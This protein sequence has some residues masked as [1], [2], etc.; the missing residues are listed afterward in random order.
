MGKAIKNRA[1]KQE[2]VSQRQLKLPGF[3][4]PF[5]QHL[6]PTNRWVILAQNI[7][8]DR[9]VNFY[10]KSVKSNYGASR[11]NGRIAIGSL[12]IKFMND[13]S[14]REVLQAI[15]ENIYMQYFLGLSSFHPQPLFDHSLLTEIRKRLPMEDLNQINEII[16]KEWNKVQT[17]KDQ[18]K[19]NDQKP[20]IDPDQ[21]KAEEKKN[22]ADQVEITHEGTLLID[23]T[24]CPQNIAYPT[25]INLLSESREILEGIIDDLHIESSKEK[26][27]RTYRQIARKEYL[28]VAKSR[29]PSRKLIRVSI[30]KQL[31][32]VRRNLRILDEY[33][34][35]Q[36]LKV[37]GA[38]RLKQTMVI[39]NLYD[40]Q[41]EMY[42]TQSHSVPDRIVNIHQPYVRPIVRGKQKA[43]VE[44][45]AKIQLGLTNGLC[46][47]DYFSWDAYNEGQYLK[48]SV[49]EYK[50]R[51]GKYP[52]EI[53]ADQIYCTREN[54]KYLKEL[55]ITLKAKP[56]GRP[57]AMS[58][59]VSPGERN[60]IEGKFGQAKIAYGLNLIKA[61]LSS[62]SA[63]WIACIV[64]VL[65]LVKLAGASAYSL[66]VTFLGE[67]LSCINMRSEKHNNFS[68]S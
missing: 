63:T 1:S 26:K 34:D 50:R 41:S 33:L 68:I 47:L 38:K 43:K 18:D 27:P 51:S 9:L 42:K 52:K 60:P 24:A 6:D 22:E 67:I 2:Y 11:I 25:D 35:E 61:K 17:D 14:D 23:A 56:L 49:E 31:Q 15:Q 39:R 44:F 30:K 3:D 16:I 10:E 13:L 46:Y 64:I 48:H 7:P 36:G 54:R 58:N 21:T 28:K 53:A 4:T 29:K 19:Q 8:W 55:G 37:L 32:Y 12:I 66:L 40:Q 62:T 57:K 59:H 65:N 5:D 45:G 20:P